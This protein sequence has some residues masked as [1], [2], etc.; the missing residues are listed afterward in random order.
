MLKD[1]VK[2]RGFFLCEVGLYHLV[3]LVQVGCCQ[4]EPFCLAELLVGVI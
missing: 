2:I 3:D 1:K 4:L